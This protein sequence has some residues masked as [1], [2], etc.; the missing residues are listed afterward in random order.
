MSLGLATVNENAR[1]ALECGSSSYRFPPSVHTANVQGAE[2]KAVAAATALQ[3]AFG[4][5]IIIAEC[6]EIT[7]KCAGVGGS[8]VYFS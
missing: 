5:A 7:E 1:S 8:R 3:G 4:T 2:G 6:T